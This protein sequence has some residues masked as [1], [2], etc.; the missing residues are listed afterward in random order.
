MKVGIIGLPSSGKTTV[1]NAV[2]GG[3]HEVHA[4]SGAASAEPNFAVVS[5]PDLRQ[6]WLK[7]LYKPKKTTYATV[8]LVDV[9]GVAPGQAKADQISPQLLTSLRQ[10]DALVNVVRAFDSAAV[11]HPSGS[12]DPLRDA[13]TLELELV[14]ADLAVVEKRLG[15]ID[16]EIQRKKGGEKTQLEL[17][18][19][20]LSRFNEHLSGENALRTLELD[21]DEKKLI[22]GYTFLSLKPIMVLAN[23]SE[24]DIGSSD[25]QSLKALEQWANGR[26][27]PFLAFCGKAEMEIA[28]LDESERA[29]FMEALGIEESSRDKFVRATYALLDLVAFFTVGEDEV[30]AWTIPNK[31][32]AQEAAGKIH[33]DIQRGF[34]RAEVLNFEQ[35]KETGSWNAA[36]EKGLVRLEGKEYLVKDG[37]CINYR[38]AV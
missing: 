30:K 9:A 8:E 1:L 20:L 37:D 19:E 5:V 17:E 26:K 28:Q 22:R 21:E 6:D 18:K 25:N 12:V 35:L 36:K 31:T 14:I 34:I 32:V 2:S 10:V 4:Y 27:M 29:E 33:T 13:E 16:Q 15:K 11:A 24:S 23:I 38:F 3:S 7:D